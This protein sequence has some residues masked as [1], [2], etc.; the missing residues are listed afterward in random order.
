MF[1]QGFKADFDN[2]PSNLEV[3][4]QEQIFKNKLQATYF[5]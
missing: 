2:E 5:S 1:D 3:L 4:S